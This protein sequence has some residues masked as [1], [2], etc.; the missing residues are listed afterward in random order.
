M[1]HNE[2]QRSRMKELASESGADIYTEKT[3]G[4]DYNDPEFQ[5]MSKQFLP[6]DLS[7]SRYYSK[8][9]GTFTLKGKISNT[10]SM[11]YRLA[12][13]NSNGTIVPCCY[14]LYSEYVMG[15][16]FEDSLKTI[17][18]NS[19][20]QAFRNKIRKDRKSISICNTCSEG[21]YCISNKREILGKCT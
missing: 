19:K 11:V 7:L 20:Y 14:D 12:V 6:N 5:N 4:I 15:N 17:W 2:H 9:D 3:V 18:K 16:V 8:Q 1:K 10:C 21:R 13:I